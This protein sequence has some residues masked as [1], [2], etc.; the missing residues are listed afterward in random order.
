M[1]VTPPQPFASRPWLDDDLEIPAEALRVPTM[2]SDEEA[3]LL[4][5]L[6]RDV[7]TGQGAIC[8]L[9]CFAGGSTA[10][11]AAGAAAAGHDVPLHAYDHFV[12]QEKQ[13]PRFLAP[14]GIAPFEGKDLLPA[15]QELLA[16]WA[17][18]L[19]L[20]KGDIRRSSVPDGA[21]EILFIDAAKTTETADVIARRFMPGLIPG[22]SLVIQQDYLHWRQPWVPAQMELMAE[23]FELVAWCRQGTAV[24][25][26][27]A[28][29]TPD[30]VDRAATRDLSDRDLDRL[31]RQAIPRF[32]QRIQ[33]RRLA[34][35]VLAVED[36]PGLRL[37]YRLDNS[38]F[39]PARVS[40]VIDGP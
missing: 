18:R 33:R 37:S 30:V 24:F 13:K 20:H 12:I 6:A 23:C 31:V 4:Y 35:S 10:R 3:R 16:P 29:V 7:A 17:D 5:W 1:P 32:P 40:A 34:C 8:D 38:R 27:T 11:L 25:R 28:P 9:G 15:A 26:C 21:I 2:L 22:H 19:H 14:A 36:N 39:T